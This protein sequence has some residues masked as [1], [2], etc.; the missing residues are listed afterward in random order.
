MMLSTFK[1]NRLHLLIVV[2]LVLAIILTAIA[3]VNVRTFQPE[4]SG[5]NIN[6]TTDNL[7]FVIFEDGKPGEVKN[8][9]TVRV[10]IK[11]IGK[12]QV[13]SGYELAPSGTGMLGILYLRDNQNKYDGT[14]GRGY[15]FPKFYPWTFGIG[16]DD[17]PNTS[18]YDTR[19]HWH[20]EE[21]SV[22]FAEN[23]IETCQLGGGFSSIE[24]NI[25]LI[26]AFPMACRINNVL[27]IEDINLKGTLT[28]RE[29]TVEGTPYLL[30]TT[31]G[32]I[33]YLEGKRLDRFVGKS[34]AIL[35]TPNHSI[36][37]QNVIVN[38]NKISNW[39]SRNK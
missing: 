22:G 16:I 20:F 39:G 9:G 27:K 38:V 10:A 33:F 5:R 12:T 18:P 29:I 25:D 15:S 7:M 21:N 37:Y 32:R 28:K 23:T 19:Y 13:P 11:N 1:V 17:R 24:N 14:L 34:V 4:A 35:G 2:F 31:D 6:P 30:T 36:N 8:P 3:T 26:V